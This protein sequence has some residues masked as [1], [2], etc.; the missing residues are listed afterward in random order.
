MKHK[1]WKDVKKSMLF[2]WKVIPDTAVMEF[3][4]KPV[5]SPTEL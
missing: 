1:K 3:G 4:M 5:L 2:I